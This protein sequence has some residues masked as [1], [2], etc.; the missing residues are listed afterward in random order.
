MRLVGGFTGLC[1]CLRLWE[2]M[3]GLSQLG[4]LIPGHWRVSRGSDVEIPVIADPASMK[5]ASRVCTYAQECCAQMDTGD[6]RGIVSKFRFH[7]GSAGAEIES[8]AKYGLGRIQPHLDRAIRGTP[9]GEEEAHRVRLWLNPQR[10]PLPKWDGVVKEPDTEEVLKD[11]T[12][13][14]VEEL[15]R[16][17]PKRIDLAIKLQWVEI[18][19]AGLGLALAV[20]LA[21][22]QFRGEP[23]VLPVPRLGVQRV[24]LFMNRD[25]QEDLVPSD[26]NPPRVG[27][28]LALS[29]SESA[30]EHS[31]QAFL[32]TPWGRARLL[33]GIE[34]RLPLEA[35]GPLHYFVVRTAEPMARE[36]V[37][38]LLTALDELSLMTA[39]PLGVHA[40]WED[41]QV[42]WGSTL[43]R[44][45]SP[46]GGFDANRFRETAAGLFA[47][48]DGVLGKG[49]WS[50]AG[51][52]FE[53]VS[54]HEEEG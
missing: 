33:D 1:L 34:Q 27:E 40:F 45:D 20:S 4:S 41:Q 16:T 3:V 38:A 39:L 8:K 10:A 9:D 37:Q 35:P 2:K 21:L 23:P 47:A 17:V 42:E 52:S 29:C 54:A 12:K 30:V 48:F 22:I 5:I 32:V 49:C 44:G 24:G 18:V 53:V 25:F 19:I 28:R 31:D 46:P 36:Q 13:A 11:R 51:R 14:W 7:T 43:T 50:L 26:L 15:A 6:P